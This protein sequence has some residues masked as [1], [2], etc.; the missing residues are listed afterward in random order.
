MGAVLAHAS[1]VP[2]P[3]SPLRLL[4][5]WA[6]EPVPLALVVAAGL[7]YWFGLRRLHSGPSWQAGRVWAWYGGLAAALVA[8]ASPVDTYSSVSFS[9]HMV[10]HVLLMFVAAPLFALGAPV[11]LALRASRPSTRRRFLLPVLHSRAVSVLTN[12]LVAFALF[13]TVQYATHLT[14]FYNAA[15]GSSPVHDLEHALYLFSAV[16]FWWPVVGLDPAPR[17]M[18]HPA[19]LMYLMLAMPLEAFL[20]IAILAGSS[21]QHYLSLP[22]PWGGAH[23]IADVS[24]AGA[25]MWI[26][27]DLG[28]LVAGLL[29]AGAWLRHDEVRQRRIEDE[30]DRLLAR[31]AQAQ[32]QAQA[33]EVSGGA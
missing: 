31:A 13:A 33:S 20:A 3:F 28:A 9:T 18:S 32:G 15:L 14:G 5:G 30:E 29:V 12:P 6:V 22:A 4:T 19:R 23:A 21:Y 7:L 8:V 17:K 27:G 2:P 24:T 25:L 16:L 11:T 26:A 10:Q 1:S